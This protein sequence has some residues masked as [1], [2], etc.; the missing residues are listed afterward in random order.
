M[1]KAPC[2]GCKSRFP[3]CHDKCELYKA[4]N[5][6][7]LDKARKA[8]EA[9]FGTKAAEWYEMSKHRRRK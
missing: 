6:K 3:A 2:Y 4:W 8:K 1:I 7:R 9:E 5:A